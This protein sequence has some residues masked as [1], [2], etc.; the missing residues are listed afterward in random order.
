VKAYGLLPS[1]SDESSMLTM[2]K[3]RIANIFLLSL[4]AIALYFCYVIAQPF[5]MPIFLAFVLAIAFHPVHAF[6]NKSIRKHNFAALVSTLLVILV[7]VVPAI[8]IGIA[9]TRELAELYQNL[10]ERSAEEGG[11][12]PYL[13]HIAEKPI[14]WLG[15]YVDLSTFDL[16]TAVLN[17]I[18]EASAYLVSF[19]AGAVGN[20][21]SLVV[22]SVIA[23]FTLFFLF[24]EGRHLRRRASAIL[25]LNE[26]Q[27]EK[28]FTGI[29][30]TITAS[31]YGT[32]AVAF[33]QGFLTSLAF[34]GLGLPSPILW[35][36]VTMIFSLIPMVG[37]GLVW[38]PASIFLLASG[39]IGKGIF[40]LAFGAGVISMVDNF[41]RPYVMSGQVKL[42]TLLLFF[43]LL[44]GVQQF[45]IIG[46]FV[47]PIVLAVTMTLFSILREEGRAW[48]STWND[49]ESNTTDS[50]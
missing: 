37:S 27:V 42:P 47:G 45:G 36:I 34:W 7:I 41:L 9:I 24:R 38:L 29:S 3:R 5:L 40:L 50:T 19:A 32:L 26:V 13:L 31:L 17:R 39:Q 25:P 4:T 18:Q 11:W 23:F 43:A 21:T 44:G 6:I 10:G 33:A 8:L 35:G 2:T 46:I 14:G 48:R 22:N 49:E 15:R 30:S 20:I 28:L 16:R 1:T 12:T